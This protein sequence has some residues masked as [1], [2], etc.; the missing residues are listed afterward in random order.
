MA[1]PKEPDLIKIRELVN[2]LIQNVGETAHPEL[3]TEI[4]ETALN[5]VS[6]AA[7]R[8]DLKVINNALKE[9]RHAFKIFAPYRNVRKVT[10]F[11][12]AR[13]QEWEPAYLQSVAFARAITEHG[14]MVITGAGEGVMKGGQAGAGR[15]KSFGMNIRLPFEQV[16]NIYIRD[17]VK[18]ITFKYFFTRKLS[19]IKETHALALFPG[20]FGTHDEGFET[21]TL[22][23][24]GKSNPL[25]VVL[26]DVPGGDF[27]KSW[28]DYVEKQLLGRGMISPEDMAFFRIADRVEQAVNEIVTFYRN[29]HSMRYVDELLVIRLQN[30]PSENLLECLNEEFADILE[31]DRIRSSPPLP[32]EVNEPELLSLPRI[33]LHFNRRNYG[34]LRQMIDR[35]NTF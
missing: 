34:R 4:I 12:S 30:P 2:H 22:L 9:M 28:R 21:L 26:L 1:D 32:S 27:W 7:D 16:P 19:F 24:T 13:T 6:D 29:Y 35:I 15:E 5:L 33:V 8:G 10:L 23:Q 11:G 3:V 25:P 20:G 31:K 18:L 17:D 14:Y